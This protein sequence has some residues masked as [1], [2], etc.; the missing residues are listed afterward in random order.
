MNDLLAIM[1]IMF[2]PVIPLFWI[3]VHLATGFFKKLGL[4]T[5][6][7]P[8]ITW[9]PLA[10]LIYQ[11]RG[12]I[13]KSRLDL[14]LVLNIAGILF[15]TA[16]TLLHI[17]TIRLLGLWGIT[18]VPEIASRHK[19]KFVVAGPFKVVRHPTY[20][21]HTLIFSGVFLITGTVSVAIVTILDCAIVN[22]I[23]IPLEEQELLNRFGEG[24]RLY[25][26]E[27]PSRFFPLRL[28]NR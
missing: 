17:W 6:I 11:N 3:P 15:F 5:Y 12:F 26:E 16:G 25:K 4:F 22:T 8:L 13:L 2:W 28:K 14:P 7:M 1:T 9:L 20:L 21:A 24:Y 19:E 10:Y 27:V 23:I 18:G